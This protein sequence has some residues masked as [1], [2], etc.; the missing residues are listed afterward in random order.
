MMGRRIAVALCIGWTMFAGTAVAQEPTRLVV[1]DPGPGRLGAIV[2][3]VLTRPYTVVI[4]DR[5]DLTLRRD[6]TIGRT[7]IV[8]GRDVRTSGTVKGDL[9]VLGGDVFLRPGARIE[10]DV[11]AA[12]GAVYDSYLADVLGQRRSF[13]DETFVARPLPE[14][15]YALEYQRLRD[16]EE[17]AAFSLPGVYGVRIPTYDRVNGLTLPFGPAFR[18]AD[19]LQVEPIVTYRSHLGKVDPGLAVGVD[20]GAT[21]RIEATAARTSETNDDWIIGDFNNLINSLWNGRD[22]RNWYRADVGEARLVRRFERPTWTLAPWVGGRWERA[23]TTGIQAPPEHLAYSFLDRTD[24]TEG[25]AR[26]NPAID[27]GHIASV[28]AGFEGDWES[29]P[30]DLELRASGKLEG[31]PSSVGDS[32]FAQLTLDGRV[33]FPLGE[34]V[35]FRVE[36]HGVGTLGDAPRQRFAYLGGSGTIKTLDL[37][38][39]GGDQL[40]YFESRAWMPIEQLRLPLVGPPVVMV[41]HMMG[42]AGDGRL[43]EFTHNLAARVAVRFVRVEVAVDPGNGETEFSFGVAFMP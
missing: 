12:G 36:G 19:A 17:V 42:S 14:G 1:R 15:G 41:R 20:V 34:K 24:T 13:R 21:T 8:I 16:E 22:T 6:T 11:I 29:R 18:I 7:L 9:V 10:G 40:L 31:A 35:M 26:P 33:T 23:W 25:M 38:V 28:I 5:G 37:L 30:H 27:E 32:E 4:G 3:E 39:Q 43:P 2:Q